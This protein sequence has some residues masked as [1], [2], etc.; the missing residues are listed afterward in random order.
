MESRFEH[1]V[2]ELKGERMTAIGRLQ[3]LD[4][5]IASIEPLLSDSPAPS[6]VRRKYKRYISPAGIARIKAAAK[7]RWARAKQSH[8]GPPND[9]DKHVQKQVLQFKKKRK[10]L[11][12]MQRPENAAKAKKTLAKMR[13]GYKLKMQQG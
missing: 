3:K 9:V 10:G 6:I 5:A 8:S 13:R 12:W 1:I 7:R 4:S 2:E 11:H